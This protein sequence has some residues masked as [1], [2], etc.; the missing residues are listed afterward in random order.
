[1]NTRTRGKRPL[2]RGRELQSDG[3]SRPLRASSGAPMCH[4]LRP[5]RR[6]R[7]RWPFSVIKKNCAQLLWCEFTRVVCYEVFK[8]KKTRGCGQ[9][10]VGTVVNRHV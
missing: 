6:R 4:P 5:M 2:R 3:D 9:A 10:R 7:A 1:V 8:K